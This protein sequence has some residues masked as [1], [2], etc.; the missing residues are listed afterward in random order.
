MHTP[1][2]PPEWHKQAAL[3]VTWPH[4][5]IDWEVP[6]SDVEAIFIQITVLTS[7]Y[8]RVIITCESK[9]HQI[10]IKQQLQQHTNNKPN[11]DY[12]IVPNNDIWVRDHG[13]ITVLNKSGATLWDFQ[14]NGWGNKFAADK[15]NLVTQGLVQAG[16]FSKK[17]Q[18]KTAQLV[19]EGGSIET[20][21]QGL[22][23][24]TNTCLLNP[25]RN[26]HLNQQAVC[27][28]LS[29]LL[30]VEKIVFL[31][32]GH[33]IGD[34]TD[35]HIDT[36][37]RFCNPH[38]LCYVSCDDPAD[39]HYQ[40]LALMQ[41]ELE[42]LQNCQG[43]PYELIKLPL[44]KAI[45]NA[46]GN[47]LPATYANFII[48]NQHIFLPVYG[49]PADEIAFE[50]LSNCFSDKT[51]VSIPSYA[52]ITQGGSLHCASMQLPSIAGTL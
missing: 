28:H 18:H 31:T 2:L 23:L 21:G 14:F 17:Y 16:A 24:T 15:D 9:T 4:I 20:D 5:G 41:A 35:G 46:T 42:S 6:L 8:Q 12:Y 1:F 13:P 36:L 25:N 45:Y 43:Q 34:D 51:V 10:H 48:T 29:N 39:P 11:I 44:P 37:A 19:L 40:P 50:R 7:A 26:P 27:Q 30:G 49:D 47:R 32:H 52:L 3:L 33:I 38:T 22:L